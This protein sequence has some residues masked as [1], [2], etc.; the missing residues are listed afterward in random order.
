MIKN[1]YIVSSILIFLLL[2]IY[3]N[4]KCE[5]FSER[6]IDKCYVINLDKRT[7]RLKHI[8]KQCKNANIDFERFSAC[9]GNNV[10]K[11]KNYIDKYFDKNNKLTKGQLG[12]ALSH[13]LIWEKIHK[14][15]NKNTLILEDDAII[16]VNFWKKIDI[17]K[18]DLETNFNI[19][20]LSCCSCEGYDINK[21]YIIKGSKSNKAN[22]CTTSYIINKKFVKIILDKIKKDKMYIHGI[23]QYLIN[24][25]YSKYDFYIVKEPFIKQNKELDSDIIMGDLGNTI[26]IININNN[27]NNNNIEL[28]TF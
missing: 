13:I 15:N 19:L 24:N 10:S 11:Y 22:W 27:N 8:T 7:D 6:F 14:N 3:I 9:D 21:K 12:C 26:K 5:Y 20:L 1:L 17:L 4:N 23:D 2:I 18:N 28:K 16:D 25:I